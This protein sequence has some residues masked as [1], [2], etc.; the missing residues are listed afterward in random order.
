VPQGA[1]CNLNNQCITGDSLGVLC[2]GTYDTPGVCV[3]AT[4]VTHVDD[5]APCGAIVEGDQATLAL[6]NDG[7]VCGQDDDESGLGHC[8]RPPAAKSDCSDLRECAP[9]AV[10]INTGEEDAQGGSIRICV[11][12][13]LRAEGESCTRTE[14]PSQV[15][16]LDFCEGLETSQLFCDDTGH[17]VQAPR[18]AAWESCR[19]I[20][21]EEGLVCI[22]DW[23]Q[24]DDVCSPM[25]TMGAACA[26][27]GQCPNDGIC[28]DPA[29]QGNEVCLPNPCM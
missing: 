27:D 8:A 4:S 6:C 10:C 5:G 16:H 11:P 2:S 25:L 15:E 7:L 21:C 17:C 19:E 28:A 29:G 1:P 23:E 13:S 14:D 26:E 18:A 22:Y 20:E 24:D 3:H 12:F 9:G